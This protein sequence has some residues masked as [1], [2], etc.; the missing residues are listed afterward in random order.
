MNSPIDH[1]CPCCGFETF[2]DPPGSYEICSVCGWEDDHVQLC[3]PEMRGGANRDSLLEAQ[4]KAL[5]THPVGNQAA[6]GFKRDC[7][8]RPL[9]ESDLQMPNAPTSGN[10]YF[11]AACETPVMYYWKR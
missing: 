6:K 5:K 9:M 3:H 8:W 4:A 2:T 11:R 10:Q 7:A 1:P